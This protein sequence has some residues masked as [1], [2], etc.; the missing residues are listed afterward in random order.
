MNYLNMEIEH[1]SYGHGI[2]ISKSYA[3]EL[4]S[5]DSMYVVFFSLSRETYDID[6]DEAISNGAITLCMTDKNERLKVDKR[7][8]HNIEF[9]YVDYY[10]PRS[11]FNKR[12]EISDLIYNMKYVEG[13]DNYKAK[14]RVAELLYEIIPDDSVVCVV[15]SSQVGRPN[16]LRVLMDEI[17]EV[18]SIQVIDFIKRV[19][20]KGSAVQGK[21]LRIPDINRN[22]VSV[23]E[24]RQL[25]GTDVILLDDVCTT[26]STFRAFSEM[27]LNHGARSVEC[28]CL[29]NTINI[30]DYI[31]EKNLY[32][33]L[34]IPGLGRKTLFNMLTEQPDFIDLE[35][36]VNTLNIVKRYAEKNK[37]IKPPT[38]LQY[39][40]YIKEAEQVFEEHRKM[41]IEIIPIGSDYYPKAFEQ[42]EMP[43]IL[44]YA[45]GN[46]NLL[47]EED[48]VAVIG[49][50]NPSEHGIKVAKRLGSIFA[51]EREIVVSGLAKGCDA[52]AHEGCIENNGKTIAILPSPIDNIQPKSNTKLAE[53][54]LESGGL[55]LSEYHTGQKVSNAYYADRDR[56]Q[57]GICNGV[58]VVE[59]S[60]NSGTLITTGHALKERKA[61]ACY[62]HPEKYSG[63]VQTQGN[64]ELLSLPEVM[65]LR[66][67]K[68]IIAFKKALQAVKGRTKNDIEIQQMKL[69]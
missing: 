30:E 45:K 61:V 34:K 33:L 28:I 19:L 32:A 59:A 18:K 22:T 50:R 63:M 44:L 48:Y 47:T 46:I 8:R 12:N 29:G 53:A 67:K 14:K 2:V 37:R 25:V 1:K 65:P 56:L 7:K 13:V 3:P 64:K 43:P 11:K 26:G 66:N 51:E 54:I 6:I 38:L 24:K 16:I 35:V 57:S 27:L 60:K 10:Y 49:T 41:G 20:D 62:V 36:F 39:A 52:N 9:K 69:F 17:S 42:I 40:E 31:R 5:N 68:D 23:Q 4:R 21:Q 15:P 55:L 58:V